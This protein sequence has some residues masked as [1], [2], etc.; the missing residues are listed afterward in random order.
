[1]HP[2]EYYEGVKEWIIVMQSIEKCT[3]L[4]DYISNKR[5]LSEEEAREFMKQLLN[6]LISCHRAGVLHRDIKD[7]N[8]LLD[9]GDGSLHLIDFGSGAFLKETDY[10][11]FDGKHVAL[12]FV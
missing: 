4:F 1:V 3:D 12:L 5:C 11:D 7:E 8:L 10:T 9:L 2:I 6:I